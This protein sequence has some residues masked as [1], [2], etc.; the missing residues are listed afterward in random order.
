[1]SPPRAPSTDAAARPTAPAALPLAAF[2][3][4][5]G[6]DPLATAF[7]GRQMVHPFVGLEPV[8]ERAVAGIWRRLCTTPRSGPSVAYLHIPFCSNHC[9]FC[10]FY[11]N[12]WRPEDGTRYVDTLVEQLRRGR[13]LPMQAGGP[14]RAVY[15]GGGT[16]TLLSARDLARVIEAAR[17]Y[18]PLAPDCEITVE[19]RI[20]AFGLDKAHAAFAAGANR[21]S[22][23]VQS[24]NDAVRRRLGRRC[25]RSA[26]VASLEALLRADQGAIVI[27]LIFGLPGQ[28]A[29]VWSDDL[30]QAI[31]LGLDGIDLYALKQ[32]RDTPLARAAAAERLVPAPA[33]SLGDY[34]RSGSERLHRARWEALS[35]THWRRGTRERNLYNLL[36]KAGADCLAFGAGAGGAMSSPAA[37][38]SYRNVAALDTYHERV[39]SGA[40]AVAGMLQQSPHRRLFDRIKGELELGRLHVT[41][42][43]AEL[44]AENGLDW[45][46][47]A[48]PLVAQ[49][50]QAGLLARDGDWLEL[51]LA[52]RFWQVQLT[53]RLLQWLQQALMRDAQSS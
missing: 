35:C 14:V 22:L 43:A 15:L 25:S 33:A 6:A 16:P 4:E 24:F 39:G 38:F 36:V 17:E 34:Y 45:E 37:G 12:A 18:L 46:A 32:M 7:R 1:M 21:V 52:G 23:G 40:P 5:A 47:L 10:G 11:Q 8:P 31:A 29:A 51:T 53:T 20:H 28:D 49:W 19:G 2:F 3:A 13:D 30:E 41:R 9:L 42:V 44:R 50:Q 26:V 48:E 27:D